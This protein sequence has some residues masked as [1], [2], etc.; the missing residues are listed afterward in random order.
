M[1]D[2]CNGSKKQPDW[3][4]LVGK[5]FCY[6]NS[7][8]ISDAGD[9]LVAANYF[10]SYGGR[11]CGR[12]RP[13]GEFRV[14]GYDS[15]GHLWWFDDISTIEDDAG[16]YWVAV[17][18]DG[19]YAAAG[20]SHSEIDTS[21]LRAYK[22]QDCDGG[23][24]QDLMALESDSSQP[25]GRTSWVSLNDDGSR[26]AVAADAIYVYERDDTDTFRLILRFQAPDPN[27]LGW[28]SA[29]ISPD[30]TRVWCGSF[31]DDESRVVDLC[32]LEEI[33]GRWK[34][35]VFQEQVVSFSSDGSVDKGSTHWCAMA[36]E[37]NRYVATVGGDVFYFAAA[38]DGSVSQKWVRIPRSDSSAYAAAMPDSGSPVATI[39]N[40]GDQRGGI[41]TY[42]ENGSLLRGNTE[43]AGNPNSCDVA[44]YDAGTGTFRVAVA[45]GHPDCRPGHFYVFDELLNCLWYHEVD[46]MCWP[47]RLSK[48]GKHMVGGSD[49]GRIYFWSNTD[50]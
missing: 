41:K 13:D 32:L 3:E 35:T 22:F 38:S 9:R 36:A 4:A 7:V 23:R 50:E 14:V 16:F 26:M 21:L 27:P 47:V 39:F 45:T 20:G 2:P 12:E 33:D 48:D 40:I 46:D 25:Q 10:S 49:N 34:T 15:D 31:S 19:E 28:V 30:G 8:A 18:A 43:I 29:V 6:V 42:D 5:E 37:E 44:G 1:A 17:S 11:G 24:N